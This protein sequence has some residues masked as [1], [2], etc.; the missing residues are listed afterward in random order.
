MELAVETV[1]K[2]WS[3]LHLVLRTRGDG[4]MMIALLRRRAHYVPNPECAHSYDVAC[5]D[6]CRSV[7]TSKWK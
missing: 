7:L 5:R 3:S 4:S 1:R 6:A 2:G